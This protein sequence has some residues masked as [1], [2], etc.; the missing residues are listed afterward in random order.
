MEGEERGI[1]NFLIKLSGDPERAREYGRRPE[2]VLADS[3]LSERQ[4]EVLRS[5]DLRRIR[6]A[7][8]NENPDGDFAFIVHIQMW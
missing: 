7:V 6:E 2:D 5:G 4:K 1:T 3:D 8:R